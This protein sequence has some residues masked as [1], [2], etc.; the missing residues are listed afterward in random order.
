LVEG[1]A[2]AWR[3]SISTGGAQ[4]PRHRL[5]AGLGDVV[6]V[7]A[8]EIG[9]M[10]RDAGI[11]GESLEEFAHQL[12]VECADLLGRKIDIPDQERPAG[13]VDGGTGQRLVHGEIEA[14]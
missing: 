2:S 6:A 14:A 5:E 13:H 1:I 9:D 4:H 7:G 10:Q 3:G 12:G 8:V 11:L